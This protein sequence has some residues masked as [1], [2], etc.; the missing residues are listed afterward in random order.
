MFVASKKNII[1]INVIEQF[2][3]RSYSAEDAVCS[4][5]WNPNETYRCTDATMAVSFSENLFSNIFI[6]KITRE[7]R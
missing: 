5:A 6:N 1:K 3:F 4:I 7:E 2:S